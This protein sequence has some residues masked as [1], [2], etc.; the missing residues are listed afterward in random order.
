[1]KMPHRA[2]SLLLSVMLLLCH[3]AI[4]LSLRD[5]FALAKKDEDTHAQIELIRRIL[6]EEP[7]DVE[8]RERLAGLWLSV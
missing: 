7:D 8:L 3:T 4:G 1:M 6:D 5:Q 2:S